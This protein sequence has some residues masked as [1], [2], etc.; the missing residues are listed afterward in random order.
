MYKKI[1]KYKKRKNKNISFETCLN[2][3]KNT[4]KLNIYRI[5]SK[6]KEIK[7]SL[8]RIK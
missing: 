5:S 8:I 7:F 3:H 2:L 1:Y 4:I 6:Y